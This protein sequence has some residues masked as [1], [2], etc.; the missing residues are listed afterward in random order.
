MAPLAKI[1]LAASLLATH[2]AA[3]FNMKYPPSIGFSDD[4]EGTAPCGSFTPDFSKANFSDFHVGGDSVVISNGHPTTVFLFRATLDEKAAGSWVNLVGSPIQVNGLNSNCNPQVPAP[5]SYEGKKGVLQVIAK[6]PDGFLY[7]CATVNFVSGA[8]AAK[9]HDGCTNSTGVTM[10][11]TGDS[12]LVALGAN[13]STP[14][15][16]SASPSSSSSSSS[17]AAAATK[18][19][20]ADILGPSSF[21]GLGTASWVVFLATVTA[22][23]RLL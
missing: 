2:V 4:D 23:W 6:S 20:A 1:A 12:E 11:Y 17:S 19:S 15:S 5:S 16:G 9:G 21:A 8:A 22:A 10:S 3:H 13:S 14:G 7:Q 18:S